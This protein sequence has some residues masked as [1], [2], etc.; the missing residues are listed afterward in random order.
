M[1][2]TFDAATSARVGL[3]RACVPALQ[4]Y[5]EHRR[6]LHR[7][8]VLGRGPLLEPLLATRRMKLARLRE[9][10]WLRRLSDAA[11]RRLR[12]VL[13]LRQ[14]ADLLPL[15]A[16]DL[17][18]LMELPLPFLA[19]RA[20][21]G[22]PTHA[23]AAELLPRLPL[24]RARARQIR[25]ILE[26]SSLDEEGTPFRSEPGDDGQLVLHGQD[27]PTIE[28]LAGVAHEVGHCLYE[29]ARPVRSTLGQIASERFAQYL[30][31]RATDAYLSRRGT[32]RERRAWWVYQRRVDAVNLHFFTVERALI[33]GS[34]P[35]GELMP[36][37]ATVLRESL[38]TLPG[39]QVV[40]AHASLSRLPTASVSVSHP[41]GAR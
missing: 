39:Y 12:Q 6:A 4:V 29:R 22:H 8:A 14:Y 24:L 26:A 35:V 9:L 30:E 41:G 28:A 2:H 15:T 33:Y 3:I 13:A 36:E 34:A 5:A 25:G 10:G 11:H 31:E 27:A 1:S 20:V 21:L 23:P 18:K 40:Y 19:D 16:R 37:P 7:Q 32:E 38:F 17:V